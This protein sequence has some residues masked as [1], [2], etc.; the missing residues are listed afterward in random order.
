MIID[1]LKKLKSQNYIPNNVKLQREIDSN[2]KISLTNE[3]QEKIKTNQIPIPETPILLEDFK[4]KITQL[5]IFITENYTPYSLV[6]KMLQNYEILFDKM[7]DTKFTFII[8]PNDEKIQNKLQK[9][10]KK[11]N[12][13]IDIIKSPIEI[14][15]WARDYFITLKNLDNTFTLFVGKRYHGLEWDPERDKRGKVLAKLIQQKYPDIKVV[16]NK[17]MAIEG[18]DVVSNLIHAFVGYEAIKTTAKLL[19]NPTQLSSELAI[20]QAIEYMSKIMNKKVIPYGKDNPETPIQEKPATFHIDMGIMP[21]DTNTILVG[22]INLALKIIEQLSEQ[23]K[24]ELENELKQNS[25][26]LGNGNILK[27]LIE[28]NKNLSTIQASF[29]DTAK[30]LQNLGYK[31]I[32]IP[33]LQGRPPSTPYITYTNGLIE[34]FKD[35][36]GKIVKRVF[37]PSYAKHLDKYAEKIYEQHGYEVIKLPLAHL[38][39]LAGAIRCNTQVL[40]RE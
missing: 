7:K 31:V 19:T 14:D 23:E 33:Y 4:G 5:L 39:T 30:M 15:L 17:K 26:P 16:V 6:Q 36:D 11:Y 21:I 38:T 24:K 3:V 18:G 29:D 8:G 25:E 35:K 32:R 20:N 13:D 27:N 22:D 28:N 9:L 10:A 34:N 37:M 1:S 12:A 40:K 2:N